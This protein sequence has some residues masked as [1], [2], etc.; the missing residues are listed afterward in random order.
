MAANTAACAPS[1]GLDIAYSASSM[2]FRIWL[3]RHTRDTFTIRSHMAIAGYTGK[4]GLYSHLHEFNLVI[5]LFC[6][7]SVK[8]GPP[9]LFGGLLDPDSGS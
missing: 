3:G 7:H 8:A 1:T 9:S 2:S 5:V 4:M 6:A